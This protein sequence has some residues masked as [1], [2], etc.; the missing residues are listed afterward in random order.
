MATP[1]ELI[2]V[3]VGTFEAYHGG[4]YQW[5][6]VRGGWERRAQEKKKNIYIYIY[7]LGFTLSNPT[8]QVEVHRLRAQ[9]FRIQGSKGCRIE[10]FG[11]LACT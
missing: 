6:V 1:R 11:F 9:G 10:D 2:P 4:G 5:G 8:N 7:G 3:T